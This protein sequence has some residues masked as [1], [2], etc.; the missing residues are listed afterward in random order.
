M[1]ELMAVNYEING[2]YGLPSNG[3]R[4]FEEEQEIDFAH[5]IQTID[6]DNLTA[7]DVNILRQDGCKEFLNEEFFS[8]EEL[9]ML[10]DE[11]VI[12]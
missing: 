10:R 4:Y 2:E 1:N 6:L 5:F 3:E 7:T 8:H 12:L 11:E 9:E